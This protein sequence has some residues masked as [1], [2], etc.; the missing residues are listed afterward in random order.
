MSGFIYNL[1]YIHMDIKINR[2]NFLRKSAAS[3]LAFG[4][5]SMAFSSFQKPSSSDEV[6]IGMIGLDTSHVIAF[7]RIINDPDEKAMEGY[8]VTTAYPT[9]GSADFPPSINRLERFTNEISDMGVEIVDSIEELLQKVDVV[10]LT[11]VDGRRHLAEALPVLE[12]GKR[13]FIDKPVAGSLKDAIAIYQ[14]SEK[15]QVP[16]FSSS[17]HR[18]TRYAQELRQGE[19]VGKIL[20]ANT[21]NSAAIEPTHPDMFWYGI[22]GIEMLFAVMGTGC[23]EVVRVHQP[24][25]DILVGTWDDGRLGTYRGVRAGRIVNGGTAF[26][27]EGVHQIGPS[28]GYRQMLVEIIRFFKTGIVPVRPEETLEIFAFM[29]AADESKRRGGQPVQ[30]KEMFSIT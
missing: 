26:G 16:V 1:K 3:G 23:K 9:R 13:M 5:G 7:T 8:R 14:A 27:E 4:L 29:E 20:G 30:L 19:L 12:A 22:H 6:R 10:L 25:Y 15:Y 28:E 11:S 2:R 21:H 17:S 24:D 18:W